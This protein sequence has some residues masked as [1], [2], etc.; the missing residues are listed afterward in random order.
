MKKLTIKNLEDQKEFT[1]Q[2]ADDAAK[3]AFLEANPI[4]A[5]VLKFEI[6]EQDISE[7]VEAEQKFLSKKE[8]RLACLEIIDEIGV[9]NTSTA[10][11]TMDAIFLNPSFVAIGMALL[12]GSPKAAKR[13]ILQVGPSLYPQEKIDFITQKLDALIASEG[14]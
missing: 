8:V 12:T 2:V 11:A 3:A 6:T 9:I 10:D 5:D 13:Y 7:Q 1:T 14:V 4:Y